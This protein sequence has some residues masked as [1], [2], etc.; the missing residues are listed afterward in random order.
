MTM[1]KKDPEQDKF[2]RELYSPVP[3]SIEEQ[4]LA[5]ISRFL[6][7]SKKF[8]KSRE[9]VLFEVMRILKRL[10]GF[11]EIAIGLRDPDGMYRYQEMTGFHREAE[12][13]RRGITYSLDD[14]NDGVSFPSIRIGK[15]SQIH[16]SEKN[17]YKPGEEKTFNHPELL[18]KPRQNVDDMIE[19]DY[20]NI[21][22]YG[23][24]KEILGWIELSG[25]NNGKLPGRDLMLWLEFFTICL[26]SILVHSKLRI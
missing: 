9:L 16:L 7:Q 20:V 1:K 2:L 8:H 14:M 6:L 23:K 15:Y 4:Y 17:P 12:N 21:F 5:E 13:A 24:N 25:P 19:G 26:V 18:G 22:L 3:D 11:K 10:S